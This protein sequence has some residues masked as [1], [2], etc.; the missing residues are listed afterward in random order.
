MCALSCVR[1]HASFLGVRRL[2]LAAHER[3]LFSE[4]AATIVCVG[5]RAGVWA[6]GHGIVG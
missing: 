1:L 5:M 3:R 2:S 6:D 4:P